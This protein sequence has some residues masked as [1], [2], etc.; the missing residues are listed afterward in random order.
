MS[1]VEPCSDI[2]T[3][4]TGT[5]GSYTYGI[6]PGVTIWPVK[7]IDPCTPSSRTYL[8]LL[9]D[10][11][12]YCTTRH[13]RNFG[14]QKWIIHLPLVV[15]G[16]DLIRAVAGARNLGLLVV[17]PAG[18]SGK[19][20]CQGNPNMKSRA[21]TVGATGPGDK[22]SS[23]SNYGSCVDIFAPGEN[24]PSIG[25]TIGKYTSKIEERKK[26]GTL[27][28]SALVAGT[29]AIF[30]QQHN[31]A[32]QVEAA[33]LAAAVDKVTDSKSPHTLLAQVPTTII[34]APPTN[35]PTQKPTPTPKPTRAPT[36]RPTCA[37]HPPVPVRVP[38]MPPIPSWCPGGGLEGGEICWEGVVSC[39]YSKECWYV[40]AI[41]VCKDYY[42]SEPGCYVPPTPRPT[43]PKPPSP[44]PTLPPGTTP[45]PT[46]PPTLPPNTP[47]PTSQKPSQRPSTPKPTSKQPT[48][49]PNTSPPTTN[50]GTPSTSPT[51]LLPKSPTA[52]P[53]TRTPTPP[54]VSADTKPPTSTP[55]I[56]SSPSTRNPSPPPKKATPPA[57]PPAT[58]AA[59]PKSKKKAK[60]A[61][62]I[63][64]KKAGPKR[65]KV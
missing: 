35:P 2:G 28:A 11:V 27:M 4:V 60:K 47:P 32:D 14:L 53:A 36:P 54:T 20:L 56:P 17:A 26:S 52:A 57:G 7:V 40:D 64:K 51:P 55:T 59:R 44:K 5:V 31:T 45:P 34:P 9:L 49:P 23:F 16:S 48:L 46:L 38:T 22:R 37:P 50:S 1:E 41:Y 25:A 18:D 3:H 6:A 13:Q 62:N 58:P 24:I 8:S 39:C 15:E 33:M 19:D 42:R 65:R 29:A 12:E 21:I 43:P 61:A 63:R 30:F 10:A